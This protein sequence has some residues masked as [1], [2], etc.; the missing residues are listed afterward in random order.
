MGEAGYA[1]TPFKPPPL[2]ELPPLEV[3]GPER[4]AVLEG[5]L[6]WIALPGG[7]ILFQEGE[8]ADSLYL[9]TTGLL[10]VVVNTAEQGQQLGAKIHAGEPVG[11]MSLITG[12]THSATVV[13]L[14]HSEFYRMPKAVFDRL[15]AEEPKFLAWIT[16]LVVQRLQRT[17]KRTKITARAAVALIPLDDSVPIEALAIA[18]I[19]ALKREGVTA[20]RLEPMAID[21][22]VEWFDELESAH[23]VVLY[24]AEPIHV[25]TNA[26]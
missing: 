11:E 9:V 5:E 15:V 25:G 14:R 1:A 13:A 3:L 18:V 6:S 4:L 16:K 7:Q 10:G 23:D 8:A 12:D 26:W 24:Q 21:Q 2:A 19:A 20:F 17:T 22:S